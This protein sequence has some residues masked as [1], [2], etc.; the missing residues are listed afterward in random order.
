MRDDE[1]VRGVIIGKKMY[2]CFSCFRLFRTVWKALIFFITNLYN[3][4]PCGNFG[5]NIIFYPFPMHKNQPRCLLQYCSFSPALFFCRLMWL[6]L[7]WTIKIREDGYF[8]LYDQL[9]P[10]DGKSINYYLPIVLLSCPLFLQEYS[11]VWWD[12]DG[13]KKYVLDRALGFLQIS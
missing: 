3:S 6:L 5:Q 8:D 10:S 4:H 12:I 2:W 1:G 7:Y 9:Y 11:W 13:G